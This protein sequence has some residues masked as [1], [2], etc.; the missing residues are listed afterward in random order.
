MIK[1]F[2]WLG[3]HIVFMIFIFIMGGHIVFIIAYILWPS[4]FCDIWALCALWITYDHLYYPPSLTCWTLFGS[5]VPA[6]CDRASCAH[7]H[8]LPQSLCGDNWEGTLFSWL[9]IYY[10]TLLLW[11]SR[12]LYVVDWLWSLILCPLISLL[13]T[14]VHWYQHC[15]TVHHVF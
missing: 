11:D 5:L 13:S 15:V 10:I 6:M 4:W 2:S 14:L 12:T 7:V 1:L 9:H 3:G 8:K